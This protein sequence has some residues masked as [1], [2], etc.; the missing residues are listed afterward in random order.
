V[1]FAVTHVEQP[2]EVVV[3][4]EGD[5]DALSAPGLWHAI[6][7][8]LGSTRHLVVDLAH[9]SFI[10]STGI[11][12]LIRAVNALRDTGQ[13]LTV[14]SPAPMTRNVFETVGLTRLIDLEP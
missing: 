6:E 2:G 14:R 9:V 10:D 7:G 5:I 8:Q 1:S 13:R 3:R 11:G 4:V 12:T